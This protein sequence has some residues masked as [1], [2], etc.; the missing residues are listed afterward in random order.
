MVSYTD[1]GAFDHNVSSGGT[2]L[3]QPVYA[4]SQPNHTV[5]LDATA[6][7]EMIWVGPGTFMMG[8]PL[9][10]MDRRADEVQHQVTLTESF[11]LK[12]FEVTQAQYQAVMTGNAQG[13]SPTP[14]SQIHPQYPVGGVSWNDIQI[15]LREINEAQEGQVN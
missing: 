9:S 14:S 8:S 5:E 15:F 11:Y 1:S 3:I 2:P 6:I 13:L 4:P 12:K 10:E 7:A